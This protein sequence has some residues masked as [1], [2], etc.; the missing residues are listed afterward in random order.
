MQAELS[1]IS[2]AMIV[3]CQEIPEALWQ[4]LTTQELPA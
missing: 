1:S 3:K 4:C 2:A